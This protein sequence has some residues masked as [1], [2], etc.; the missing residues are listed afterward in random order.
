ME[1]QDKNIRTTGV[2]SGGRE[3]EREVEGERER[4]RAAE[5]KDTYMV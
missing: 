2:M 3:R 1:D 4:E 5:E